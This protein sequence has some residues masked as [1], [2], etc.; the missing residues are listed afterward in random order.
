MGHMII[1]GRQV[2]LD[3]EKN[4]LSVIRKAGIDLP[5]LCYDPDLSPYGACRMCLVENERGG[6]IAACAEVPYDG[7]SVKTN[8]KKLMKHR[9]L[10][11][12]LLLGSHCR[13]CLS[14]RRSEKCQLQELAV[15]YG[16]D[17]I[18]FQYDKGPRI[19]DET[20]HII[21]IDRI[22]CI[23]CG[24]CIRTCA[25]RQNVGALD[26]V[27]RGSHMYVSTAFDKPLGETYCTGCGQCS[28]SCPTGAIT[29]K[30]ETNEL[31]QAINDD[32]FITVALVDPSIVATVGAELGLPAGEGTAGKLVGALRRIGFDEVYYLGGAAEETRAEEVSAFLDRFDENGKLPWITSWCPAWRQ[33]VNDRHPDLQEYLSASLSPVRVMSAAVKAGC[34]DA[35]AK[36][37]GSGAA[38]AGDSSAAVKAGGAGAANLFI[39]AIGPCTALKHEL[40]M[41]RGEQDIDLALTARELV[42]II[43]EMGLAPGKLT[44]E[45]PDAF[46]GDGAGANAAAGGMCDAGEAVACAGEAA[47]GV[48]D[49][50]D[51]AD[52][53]CEKTL[54]EAV[55][56]ASGDRGVRAVTVY[57]LANAEE[58]IR[59]IKAGDVRYDFIEVLAC[60]R[61]CATGA[62]HPLASVR[63]RMRSE[64]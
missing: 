32:A 5:T 26:F 8:T 22:K 43:R 34:A 4:V 28:V 12:E 54:S 6:M 1:N 38:T 33:Y 2:E 40:A 25:E 52:E 16:V 42:L 14:C 29:V 50:A 37:G 61:G 31:W 44:P 58:I 41:G 64:T 27:E 24:S 48:T 11:L 46:A 10:M 51:A 9:K 60:P 62:G 17:A 47:A 18:R 19:V 3:G 30:K 49:A 56:D 59:Q 57:G 13:D 63:Q 39:T 7:L 45:T 53:A 21:E 35:A 36:A 23:L 55:A 15:R 20:G